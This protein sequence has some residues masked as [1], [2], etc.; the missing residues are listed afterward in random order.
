MLADRKEEFRDGVA[1]ALDHAGKLG[2]GMVICLVSLAPKIG[3]AGAVRTTLVENLRYA[4]LQ[5]AAAGIK[6]LVEPVNSFD[7][8]GFHLDTAEKAV[9]ILDEAG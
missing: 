9:S 2:C 5:F 1:R 6:L 4:A 8:P 3:E 7:I